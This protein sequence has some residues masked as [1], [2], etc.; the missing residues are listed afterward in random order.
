MF[1]IHQE[2]DMDPTLDPTF[3]EEIVYDR[4]HGTLG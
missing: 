1:R 4:Y 3:G 2:P